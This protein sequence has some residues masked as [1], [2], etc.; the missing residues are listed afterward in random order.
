MSW[1][2]TATAASGALGF[3]SNFLGKKKSGGDTISADQMIPSWQADSG[4][5]LSAWAQRFLPDYTPGAAYGGQFTAGMSPEEQKGLGTLD[6]FLNGPG[7][8][9][10]FAA[11]KGQT[12]DTLG[13]KY[14]DPNQNPWIK[15]MT[16]L[17]S[18]NLGDQINAARASEGARGNFFSSGSQNNERLLRERTLNNLNAT[19]GQ[20][21]Q[22]ERQNQVNA[23]PVAQA[24]DQYANNTVPLSQVNA[25]QTYGALSRTLSQADLESQY[26]DY[27]RQRNELSGVPSAAQGVYGTQQPYGLKSV[28]SPVTETN[29]PLANILGLV[30]KLNLGSLGG[31]GNIWSNLGGLFTPA[32]T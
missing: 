12:L 8:G 28:T 11:A 17:S 2:A 22:T 26:N 10:L 30:S 19:V 32:K 23:V 7:T 25:S 24:L 29:T 9:D 1:V 18:Q 14:L 13:G 31:G 4:K 3:A 21:L 20:A 5:A 27:L 6:G 16:A 15:S